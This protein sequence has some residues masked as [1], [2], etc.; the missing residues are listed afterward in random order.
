MHKRLAMGHAQSHGV[1]VEA[2]DIAA[3]KHIG[4]FITAAFSTRVVKVHDTLKA[5]LVSQLERVPPT[6]ITAHKIRTAIR[7][8]DEELTVVDAS[9]DPSGDPF[10]WLSSFVADTLFV[11]PIVG[12][13]RHGNI[14]INALLRSTNFKHAQSQLDGLSFFQVANWMLLLFISRNCRAPHRM[15]VWRGSAKPRQVYR[16]LAWDFEAEAWAWLTAEQLGAQNYM[17]LVG[18]DGVPT[19]LDIGRVRGRLPHLTAAPNRVPLRLVAR[20]P[21]TRRSNKFGAVVREAAFPHIS[22][23]PVGGEFSLK[24]FTSTSLDKQVAVSYSKKHAV[25]VPHMT[26]ITVPPGAGIADLD[27]LGTAW[28]TDLREI[29]LPPGTKLSVTG[30]TRD[31]TTATVV[32]DPDVGVRK[33]QPTGF[34][35]V[36]DT[37]LVLH[38]LMQRVAHFSRLTGGH[39]N[40]GGRICNVFAEAHLFR[41]YEELTGT[42]AADLAKRVQSATQHAKRLIARTGFPD[43]QVGVKRTTT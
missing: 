3:A 21:S 9:S 6:S 22:M 16:I 17:V 23:V 29:L 14:T 20:R 11:T 43:G 28:K 42:A 8:V 25:G 18:S 30:H 13:N 27:M 36:V 24:A 32:V 10:A 39:G 40:G 41:L 15:T 7:A 1:G 33:S 5:K 31:G 12:M 4:A 2:K 37:V 38:F 19:T 34:S 26:T 35:K